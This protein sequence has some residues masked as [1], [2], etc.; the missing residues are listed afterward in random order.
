MVAAD[1]RDSDTGV[2][3]FCVCESQPRSST[4]ASTGTRIASEGGSTA[5]GPTLIGTRTRDE[6]GA[7]KT[8]K[9]AAGNQAGS[10]SQSCATD[11]GRDSPVATGDESAGSS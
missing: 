2:G 9:T 10:V 4:R 3:N 7:A 8:Q 6:A 1:L 5:S 11:E